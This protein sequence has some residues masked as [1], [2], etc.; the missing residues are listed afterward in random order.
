[1]I[2]AVIVVLAARLFIVKSDR[3]TESMLMNILD[4]RAEESSSNWTDEALSQEESQDNVKSTTAIPVRRRVVVEVLSACPK[5]TECGGD[6]QSNISNAGPVIFQEE[7]DLRVVRTQNEFE[8]V[9]V[10]NSFAPRD[11]SV[12][13][14]R[15]AVFGWDRVQP[16]NAS[17]N[18]IEAT[19]VN[20]TTTTI[21]SDGQPQVEE[22]EYY[23]DVPHWHISEE[24]VLI[25]DDILRLT[26]DTS[27][28]LSFVARPIAPSSSGF[29]IVLGPFS[30]FNCQVRF[31]PNNT[32]GIYFTNQGRGLSQGNIPLPLNVTSEYHTITLL[33]DHTN[34]NG[35][36]QLYQDDLF[37]ADLDNTPSDFYAEFGYIGA[38][39]NNQYQANIALR[40]IYIAKSLSQSQTMPSIRQHLL[41]NEFGYSENKQY[42]YGW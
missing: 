33:Y 22:K 39:Y 28:I 32:L 36:I 23:G 29:D 13:T 17:I 3:T 4:P 35:K 30:K 38:W 19:T 18:A 21:S 25:R 10:T 16:T 40:R 5:Q 31:E 41:Q 2:G 42:L 14:G 6:V 8:M 12:F 11:I 26:P 34:D 37:V 20:A 15:T 24:M 7:M 1:M 9:D 27:W